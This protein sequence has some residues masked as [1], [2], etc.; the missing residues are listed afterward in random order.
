MNTA[1]NPHLKQPASKTP[2]IATRVT[3]D[4]D[5]MLC[6]PA[7]A[8]VRCV[9]LET[10]IYDTLRRL[11]IDYGD[12]GYWHF[13]KLSNGGF[14][15]APDADKPFRIVNENYFEG[16]V[17]ANTAGLIACAAAYTDLSFLSSAECFIN[18]YYRLSDFIFQHPDAAMIR[19]ALD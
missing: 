9:L 17:S 19:A 16:E 13:Y 6:L 2:I 15:M 12:G 18:A 7:I 11:S 8:G 5:R 10:T 4:R 3:T 14:Y 1:A